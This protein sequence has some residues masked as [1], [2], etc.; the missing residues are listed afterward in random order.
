M[1]MPQSALLMLTHTP[2]AYIPRFGV[3]GH[4]NADY[5]FTLCKVTICIAPFFD[6]SLLLSGKNWRLHF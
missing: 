4:T 2:F 1:K 5:L 6:L 3:K